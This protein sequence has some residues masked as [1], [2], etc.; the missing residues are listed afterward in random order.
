MSGPRPGT[1]ELHVVRGTGRA[2]GRI[3]AHVQ[4]VLARDL[5]A[6][7]DAARRDVLSGAPG[8]FVARAADP[9]EAEQAEAL[10]ETPAN[11]C[12]G[13]RCGVALVAHDRHAA[14]R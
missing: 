7:A 11:F 2:V 1:A 10:P 5:V 6:E 9:G 14:Q 12:F 8:T 4:P 13:L 3:H